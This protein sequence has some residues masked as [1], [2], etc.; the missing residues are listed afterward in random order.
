MRNLKRSSAV[1]VP[2][3]FMT[4]FTM[5][6]MRVQSSVLYEEAECERRVEFDMGQNTD[7]ESGSRIRNDNLRDRKKKEGCEK[8]RREGKEKERETRRES[9]REGGKVRPPAYILHGHKYPIQQPKSILKNTEVSS[10]WQAQAS[11]IPFQQQ[12][13]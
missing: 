13:S 7:K 8:E 2:K 9:K 5:S 4:P 3:T 11:C 12:V 1:I 10:N 6:S